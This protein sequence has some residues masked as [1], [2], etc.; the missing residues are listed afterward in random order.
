VFSSVYIFRSTQELPGLF[1]SLFGGIFLVRG[2]PIFFQLAFLIGMLICTFG[3]WRFSINHEKKWKIIAA[4]S[5]F[6]SLCF[7]AIILFQP[8]DELFIF[9]RHSKH[10]AENGVFSFN[11]LERIEGI[12]DFLP[13]FILGL[14]GKVGFPLLET[15]FVF[16]IL[17][18]W[19]CI[20]G[21]RK[22]LMRLELPEAEVWSYPLLTLYPPLLLNTGNG[23]TVLLFTASILWSLVY[24]F[25][26]EK[27][28][29]GFFFLA[30]V[31]L[32]RLEGAWFSFLAFA[33]YIWKN[34][35]HISKRQVLLFSSI[36]FSPLVLLSFW[37]FSYFGDMIPVPIR[38]K[39]AIG[40]IFYF[41]LGLR[42]LLLDFFA[43]GGILFIW[44]LFSNK[45]KS[46]QQTPSP[47]LR[48]SHKILI[49]LF[50]FC[51]PYYL[52]G[53]DWF[54]AAWGRYL[55]PFSFTSFVV[56]LS[57]L[58][59]F[60]PKIKDR[61]FPYLIVELVLF[62]LVFALPFGSFQRL[63]ENLFAPRNSL[64]GLHSK[65][66]G[67]PNYRIQYLSQL[68]NHLKKTTTPRDVI[69]SSE[70]ATIMYFADREALDLL[71]VANPEIAQAPLRAAP[72]LL[73]K[74]TLQ[75]EL[76][77]LIFK[78][79]K[80]DMIEKKQPEIVYAFDFIV[81]DLLENVK[82]EEVTN[83]DIFLALSRW[84]RQ[85]KLLNDSLFGGVSELGRLGYQPIVVQY[86]SQF[87]SLYFVSPKARESHFRNLRE[88]GL[89]GGL[90]KNNRL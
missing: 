19:L 86:G 39:S 28:T 40:H 24:C 76:P 43:G 60:Q 65:K 53:G 63:T 31:P 77:R 17:G 1:D 16:G 66:V 78:R 88:N 84:D 46:N 64:A 70:V 13:F 54:P 62:A 9:L 3:A 59:E 35:S 89:F 75:N 27:P 48:N 51:L 74:T 33:F 47:A 68:G 79:L 52:S 38:F 57:Q 55:F 81:K 73:S 2:I 26:E 67:K 12:V 58:K 36:V 83:A 50:V 18:G 82:L 21:G 8:W 14:L 25:F 41:I 10:L 23:F 32:I 30:L 5:C 69:A 71:G 49:L 22:M 34:K 11:R 7:A 87:F 20:L 42:N 80:P 61:F 15:N 6:L 44:Y 29:R 45:N 4:V 90:V 37:R 72:H 56:F 85:F